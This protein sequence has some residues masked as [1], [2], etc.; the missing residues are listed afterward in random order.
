MR[1]KPNTKKEIKIN[2]NIASDDDE[3]DTDFEDV[4]IGLFSSVRYGSDWPN[5]PYRIA[6]TTAFQIKDIP[7]ISPVTYSSTW[8]KTK[9]NESNGKSDSTTISLIASG[10]KDGATIYWQASSNTTNSFGKDVVNFY[11]FG[12]SGL[13]RFNGFTKVTN[14]ATKVTLRPVEDKTTEGDESL[15]V[16]FF[17]DREL[18][19]QIHTSSPIVIIDTSTNSKPAVK[20]NDLSLASDLS[21]REIGVDAIF[22]VSDN[23]GDPIVAYRLLDTPGAGSGYFRFADKAY[24]GEVLEV[25]AE[26][27]D[28]VTWVIGKSGSLDK[29]TCYALDNPGNSAGQWGEPSFAEWTTKSPN[30]L[31]K[32]AGS[33]RS[34][35]SI[36]VAPNNPKYFNNQSLLESLDKETQAVTIQGGGKNQVVLV[37][38]SDLIGVDGGTLIGLDGGTLIGVDGGTLIGLDGGTLIGVDGGT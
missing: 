25:A 17:S 20:V 8:S 38:R 23:E 18:T 9:V 28:Q 36:L 35:E 12:A 11:D 26:E 5:D 21:G 10:M 6:N 15:V 4:A 13:E 14:E 34:L 22:D 16:T 33:D 1:L 24:D 30:A 7:T 27:L 3:S 29:I 31:I 32:L 2:L 37:N 19:K